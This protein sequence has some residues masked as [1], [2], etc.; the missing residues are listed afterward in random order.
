M[1]KKSTLKSK[2]QK[3][4]KIIFYIAGALVLLLLFDISPFGG[5]IRFYSK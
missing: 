3:L 5:N 4:V 2:H 1:L